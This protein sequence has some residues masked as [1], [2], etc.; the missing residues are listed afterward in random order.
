MKQITYYKGQLNRI[1]VN[2]TEYSPTIKVFANGNGT[3]TNHL[4]LNEESAKALIE[5]LQ[6]NFIHNPQTIKQ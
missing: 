4:S 3:D 1:Q 2:K 5:W 6:T